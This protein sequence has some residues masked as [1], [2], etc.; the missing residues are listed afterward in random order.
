M[1]KR[2]RDFHSG[3]GFLRAVNIVQHMEHKLLAEARKNPSESTIAKLEAVVELTEALI[4]A[5]DAGDYSG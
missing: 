2:Y 1:L 3:N 5:F 4:S